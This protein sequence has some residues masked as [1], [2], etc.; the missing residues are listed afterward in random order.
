MPSAFSVT[1]SAMR[2]RQAGEIT[3][4]TRTVPT[5]KKDTRLTTCRLATIAVTT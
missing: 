1:G 3:A 5:Y 4:V 2:G